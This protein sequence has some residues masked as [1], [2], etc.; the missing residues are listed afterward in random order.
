M[1]ISTMSFH[2]HCALIEHR[3]SKD[4]KQNYTYYFRVMLSHGSKGGM[5]PISLSSPSANKARTTQPTHIEIMEAFRLCLRIAASII[6]WHSERVINSSCSC[7]IFHHQET[8][9][10]GLFWSLQFLLLSCRTYC[11]CYQTLRR[12][13]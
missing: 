3:G 2:Y 5:T 9:P 1:S 6:S 4:K 7:I 11:L 10:E 8:S 13:P 12:S